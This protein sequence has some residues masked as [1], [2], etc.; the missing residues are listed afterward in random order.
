RRRTTPQS[1]RR[2]GPRVTGLEIETRE[3]D[4][5]HRGAQDRHSGT[6]VHGH[7]MVTVL[8]Q[9]LQEARHAHLLLQV[10]SPL[11]VRFGPLLEVPERIVEYHDRMLPEPGA[12]TLEIGLHALV[13][14]IAIYK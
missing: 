8:P 13:R 6:D 7:R 5:S 4:S 1:D 2:R 14:I 9:F 3:R 12:K 11:A 10:S